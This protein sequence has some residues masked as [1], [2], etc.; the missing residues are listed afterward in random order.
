[1]SPDDK[2]KRLVELQA[3]QDRYTQEKNNERV[4]R[5]EDVLVE[6]TSRN[7]SQDVM[8]RTGSNKIVN[9]TGGRNLIGKTVR[10]RIVEAFLHSLRG[11]M[12]E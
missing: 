11:E 3:L 8:G 1:V 2:Q 10:V 7:T 5:T 9:F 4:G 12:L 6:G